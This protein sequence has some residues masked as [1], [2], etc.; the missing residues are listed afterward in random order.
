MLSVLV[1]QNVIRL[2]FAEL[3]GIIGMNILVAKFLLEENFTSL[4][5]KSVAQ[6]ISNKIMFCNVY[7]TMVGVGLFIA[8]IST[9]VPLIMF[10]KTE[11][12]KLIKGEV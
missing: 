11:P 10:A 8:V 2:F 5:Y 6:R 1:W 7:P 3:I 12:V 9:V 4:L